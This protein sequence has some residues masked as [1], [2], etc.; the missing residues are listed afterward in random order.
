VIDNPVSA[1][2]DL[3]G[4]PHFVL[5]EGPLRWTSVIAFLHKP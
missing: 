4:L 2:G 3:L 5:A 1:D